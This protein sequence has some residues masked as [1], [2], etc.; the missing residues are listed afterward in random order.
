MNEWTKELTF[1]EAHDMGM[2][3]YNCG[4]YLDENNNDYCVL[5]GDKRDMHNRVGYC[6]YWKYVGGN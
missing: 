1:A 4:F 6:K 3:C 2:S 5:G